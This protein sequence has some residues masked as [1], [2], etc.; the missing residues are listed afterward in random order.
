[1]NTNRGYTLLFAILTATLVLGVAVF[2]T[3]VSKKQYEL[4]VTARDSIY[5]FYAA[6]SAIE[7]ATDHFMTQPSYEEGQEFFIE[8]CAGISQGEGQIFETTSS[9][10]PTV[11][12]DD[13]IM[14]DGI[15]LRLPEGT[16]ARLTVTKGPGYYPGETVTRFFARGYNLCSGASPMV[17][18]RVLERAVQL[19]FRH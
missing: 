7:C 1:M 9:P 8:K 12:P 11:W 17:S 19:T 10:D 3:S 13:V 4:S 2:I 18:V 16:C 6:D 5:A 15:E 14:V